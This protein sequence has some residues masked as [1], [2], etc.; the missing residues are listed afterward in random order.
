MITIIAILAS[1]IT[2][3]ASKAK[4]QAQRVACRVAIKSYATDVV[5]QSGGLLI[6]I[7][8]EANCYQCHKPPHYVD[9]L[10]P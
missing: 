4:R 9:T 8:Q 5:E 3:A 6:V 7:P 10:N 1:L 2:S